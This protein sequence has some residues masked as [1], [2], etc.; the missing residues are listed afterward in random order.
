M[1]RTFPAG[2][3]FEK[4]GSSVSFAQVLPGTDFSRS[5]FAV[6]LQTGCCVRTQ[7]IRRNDG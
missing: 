2:V 5:R 1:M 4:P 6:F 3:L 7:K